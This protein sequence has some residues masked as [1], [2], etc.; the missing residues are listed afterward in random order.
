MTGE[1]RAPLPIV[2]PPFRD[3]RLSSWLERVADVY[4]VSLGE[5]QAHVGWI[6]PALQLEFEPAQADMERI[7]AATSSSVERLF[8]M[9][10][11]SATIANAH[12]PIGEGRAPSLTILPL[13][14][15]CSP[16]RRG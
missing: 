8:A 7:A 6:R 1:G 9:T 15:R 12:S 13:P 16:C 10:G 11:S 14:A 4:L 5:L 2:P 3:E